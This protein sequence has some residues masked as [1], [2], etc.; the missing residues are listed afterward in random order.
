MSLKRCSRSASAAASSARHRS[1]SSSRRCRSLP[2]SR[3]DR[4]VAIGMA[5]ERSVTA[6]L[7]DSLSLSQVDQHVAIGMGTER[8][9]TAR[10]KDARQ[11]VLGCGLGGPVRALRRRQLGPRRRRPNLPIR[12]TQ[13]CTRSAVSGGRAR[14]RTEQAAM[15]AGWRQQRR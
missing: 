5:T 6:R 15:A 11:L 12:K 2:P 8:R 13:T 14:Q 7:K 10:L 4:H 1:S 9:V 3:M